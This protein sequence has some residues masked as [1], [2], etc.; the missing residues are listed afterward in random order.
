MNSVVVSTETE[1]AK[2]M[3]SQNEI[4][5]SLLARRILKQSVPITVEE[6]TAQLPKNYLIMNQLKYND[7]KRKKVTSFDDT[8]RKYTENSSHTERMFVLTP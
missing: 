6:I 2:I 1:C 4:S 5:D 3:Q 8:Q 7:Q